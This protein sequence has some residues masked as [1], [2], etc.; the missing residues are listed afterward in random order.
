SYRACTCLAPNLVQRRIH[1][2]VGRRYDRHHHP[3]KPTEQGLQSRAPIDVDRALPN[4]DLADDVTNRRITIPV[5][6]ILKPLKDR[7]SFWLS[8]RRSEEHTSEL[9]SRVDLVCRLL[10]EKKKQKKDHYN[11]SR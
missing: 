2:K 1:L 10:L 4:D 3:I 7:S 11:A 5:A 9:Q 6:E 8:H